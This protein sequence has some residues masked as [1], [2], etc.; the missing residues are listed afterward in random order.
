MRRFVLGICLITTLLMAKMFTTA[1]DAPPTSQPSICEANL[2]Q[3]YTAATDACLGAPDGHVCNGGNPP[4]AEPAGAVANSLAA[5][6]AVVP[7]DALQSITTTALAPDGSNGGLVWVRVAETQMR[8]LMIGDVTIRNMIDPAAV[9]FPLWTAFTVV[10][11]QSA[12]GC[13]AEPQSA[14]IIQ[15]ANQFQQIRV[16]VN[17]ASVDLNGTVLIK[18]TGLDTVFVVLEGV[19]RLLANG[20]S[21]TL[22]AG[23]ESRINHPDGNFSRAGSAPTEP[24][25]YASDRIT[26]IPVE[27]LD[28]A[29]ILPQPGFVATE[30][31]VNLRTA[32]ST[33]AGIIYQVPA[34][35]I[36][37]ILGSNPAGD[38]Y[39]VRL[40]NGQTGWMFAELL[41]RNHGVITAQYESTPLPPQRYGESGHTALVASPNG[42]TA[43]SAPHVGFPAMFSVG[44]GAQLELLARSPYSP[45]V[46]IE[47]GGAVG[48]V[49]LINLET[50]AIVE[51]LPVD[52]NV[53]L[54]PEPTEPPGQWGG[55]F[56]DPRC[57]PNC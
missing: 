38:W 7:V 17:G 34:G 57:Y 28:R 55:A 26:H 15:N 8:G 22:V 9:D 41:R 13:P 43:R 48:W 47:T 14:F 53:P 31:A 44:A 35:Q 25:P 3:F 32:P 12:P 4:L 39:H 37:T 52:Y 21:Q 30:G 33:S 36:M 40:A 19:M 24:A 10:T 50:R 54:P 51:S 11:G 29:V 27:L 1:Q 23:Q 2:I 46:K 20:E 45:W 49:P 56:P 42:A 18:T 5:F 6:G 16:V